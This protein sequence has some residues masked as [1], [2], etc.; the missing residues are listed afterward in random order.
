MKK[1]SIAQ[2]LR[3]IKTLKGNL[4]DLT[5]R[6]AGVVSYVKEDG[7]PEFDFAELRKEIHE[8]RENLISLESSVTQAN[9]VTKIE[10]QGKEM[11]LAEAIRR[12]QENKAE[13]TWLSGLHFQSGTEKRHDGYETDERGRQTP[14][15]VIVNHVSALSE[16]GRLE[17]LKSLKERFEELNNA[18]E[19]ANHRTV[20]DLKEPKLT[21]PPASAPAN[22]A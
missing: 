4:A 2:A 1:L 11:T 18:L 21:Q 16:K 20:L 5:R 7:Q 14:R 22:E 15:V 8:T 19:S 9:A 10:A 12:L 3:A 17:E 13:Q 6:A